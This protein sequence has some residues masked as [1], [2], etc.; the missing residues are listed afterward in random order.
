LL[1]V[2]FQAILRS[3]STPPK[4]KPQGGRV[5]AKGTQSG[6]KRYTAPIPDSAKRSPIWVPIL[7]FSFLGLGA[8]LII[9][10][11]TGLVPGGEAS[12]VYLLI[13]LGLILGGIITATQLH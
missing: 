6:G 5:T 7:L 13:G 4:R 8:V 9:L 10:N 11:Y 2:L 3:M 12:N 1:K